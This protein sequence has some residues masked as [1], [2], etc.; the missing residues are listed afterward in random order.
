MR[1]LRRMLLVPFAALCGALLL[2]GCGGGGAGTP[3]GSGAAKTMSFGPLVSRLAGTAQA[4]VTASS[5][6]SVATGVAGATFSSLVF[7]DASPTLAETRIAFSRQDTGLGR[8][9]VYTMAA[10]G[11]GLNRISDGTNWDWSPAWSP[12]GTKIAFVRSNPGQIYAM[13]ADGS[14]VQ[15]IS[16]GTA[17]DVF[18]SWSPDGTK[19]AF[20]RSDTSLH[21]QIYVMG[22]DGSSPHRISDGTTNDAIPAW[23][24]DG[25]R[26][27]V[28]RFDTAVGTAQIYVMG[29]DGS[30]LHRLS[31]GGYTDQTPAWSPDGTR[32]AFMRYEVGLGR[33]QIWVMGADGSNPH[34]I[35]NGAGDD[36]RPTWSPDGTRIA[37]ERNDTAVGHWQDYVMQADGTGIHRVSD[38][39]TDDGDPS[40]DTGPAWSPFIKSRNLIGAGGTMGAA[41]AGF[42]YGES[43]D[44]LTS[45]LTFDTASPDTRSNAQIAAQNGQ[46]FSPSNLLFSITASDSLSSLAYMNDLFSAPTIVINAGAPSATGALASINSATGRIASVLPYSADLPAAPSARAPTASRVGGALVCRGRFVGVW[47]DKGRNEAPNGASKVRIDAATGKLLGFK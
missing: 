3:P 37:F 29:T 26:I 18:P 12:D 1:R 31:S 13:G 42:L 27:A 32:I 35:D 11:S 8:R 5:A 19:I 36:A 34:R 21:W 41:A 33:D 10:D 44:V 17:S 20:Q 2:A 16:D 9:Q 45:V 40:V 24:P 46:N 38:G 15:R 14:G 7:Q 22:A 39:T 47:D 43:G 30:N 28:Q 25:K 4:P 23:S 6:T